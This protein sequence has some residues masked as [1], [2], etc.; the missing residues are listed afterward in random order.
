VGRT[1][2]QQPAL[3][4]HE[5]DAAIA[6][7]RWLEA[8]LAPM[9]LEGVARV[10][11]RT[12]VFRLAGS[13]GYGLLAESEGVLEDR[14]GVYQTLASALVARPAGPS[15]A[16]SLYL[17][18]T[19]THGWDAWTEASMTGDRH[20]LEV[21][22]RAMYRERD[23]RTAE[24]AAELDRFTVTELAPG[25]V[26]G[27]AAGLSP[28]QVRQLAAL[29]TPELLGEGLTP[30][31]NRR[32]T[33][34]TSASWRT[35]ERRLARA[36]ER[37]PDE[38]FLILAAPP[39]DAGPGYYVQF[40][41]ATTVLRAEAVLSP[42]L[43]A[44][45]PLSDAQEAGLAQLGWSWPA[46][47]DKER[48]AF[49]MWD[50]PAPAAE[51]AHLVVET[52]RG[53]YG[54]DTPSRLRFTYA[55]FSG[56]D[57]PDPKLG[58]PRAAARTPSRA[59]SS[60]QPRRAARAGERLRRDVEAALATFIGIPRVRPDQDG[61]YPMRS[62]SAIYFVR[63]LEGVPPAIGVFSPVLRDVQ[64][65]PALFEALNDINRRIRHARIFV[66]HAT[67]YV[68]LELPAIGLTP[69]HVAFGCNQ[70]GGLAD[71]LDDLLHGRFGGEVAFDTSPKLLN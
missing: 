51:A 7:V 48:N 59:R 57:L 25:A 54:I 66:D 58:I 28:D 17:L 40:A 50:M 43:P 20:W 10:G 3:I 27:L 63:I 13:L 67:V 11:R 23:R 15:E 31:G 69:E 2:R 22:R 62:G 30:Q 53:V 39:A 42:Y 12:N 44:H 71:D 1:S 64:P 35:F 9:R 68:A 29:H 41:Q 46:P 24:L 47:D 55:L 26:P 4:H 36:V 8:A 37:M 33:P 49:R 61:D 56:G 70:L 5:S 32:R 38:S 19:E 34:G 52:L 45:A 6:A 21:P 16:R 18:E 65:S 14:P 60:S